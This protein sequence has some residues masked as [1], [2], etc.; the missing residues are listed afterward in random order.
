MDGKELLW[1]IF[2]RIIKGGPNPF[3]RASRRRAHRIYKTT[4]AQSTQRI[5]VK[6]EVKQRQFDEN[7]KMIVGV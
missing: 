4:E 6:R 2:S 3:P 7:K 5:L 1:L